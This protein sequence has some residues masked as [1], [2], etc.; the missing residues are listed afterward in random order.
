VHTGIA[1]DIQIPS[2]IPFF[3]EYDAMVGANCNE[4]QWDEMHYSER[5]K[6]VAFHR[7]KKTINLHEGDALKLHEQH[8]LHMKPKG[9]RK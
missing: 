8:E 2:L 4:E 3:E 5:A 1:Y 9:M 6:A 7:L